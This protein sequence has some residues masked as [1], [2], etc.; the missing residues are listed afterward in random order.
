MFAKP[1]YHVASR[2]QQHNINKTFDATLR[3][4]ELNL[5]SAYRQKFTGIPSPYSEKSEGQVCPN[6]P[7]TRTKATGK[8]QGQ[9]GAMR[10]Q[11]N[12]P[13][14]RTEARGGSQEQRGAMQ[15]RK[16]GR[17]HGRNPG[18]KTMGNEIRFKVSADHKTKCSSIKAARI[19]KAHLVRVK[20]RGSEG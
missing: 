15:F 8:H 20:N 14:A 17:P 13:I 10:F 7:T 12:R 6:R 1:R 19:P 5:S 11:Q 16:I 18:G 3:T 9:R 4:I 2:E